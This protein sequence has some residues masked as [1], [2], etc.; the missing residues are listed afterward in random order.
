[1]NDQ[2]RR[3]HLLDDI[4]KEFDRVQQR[5]L[6]EG[7]RA[8]DNFAAAREVAKRAAKAREA[9]IADFR[10]NYETRKARAIE[11]LQQ[12]RHRPRKA[13]KP[14]GVADPY[15]SGA[16]L[17]RLADGRVRRDHEQKLAEIERDADEKLMELAGLREEREQ[18]ER[19]RVREPFNREAAETPRQSFNRVRRRE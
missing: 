9:E 7:L 15:L 17:E 11:Q 10:L 5:K 16:E 6:V 4:Q 2:D 3:P 1:M 8:N 13:L 18:G 12:E 19:Q 14:R